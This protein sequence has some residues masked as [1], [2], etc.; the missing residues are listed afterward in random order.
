MGAIAAA[1]RYE[2]IRPIASGGMATVYL[3]RASGLGG[4]ERLVAIKRMHPHIAAEPDFVSMFLDEARLAAGIRHPNVV[5]TIDVDQGPEGLFLVMEYVDGTSLSQILRTMHTGRRRLPIGVTLRIMLDVL[6]GL[7]AAHEL[8]TVD[9]QPLNLVHRDVSPPNILV[10]LDGVARITDF[11]VARAEARITSTR[12]GTLKGKIAYMSP[13]QLSGHTID[14]RADVYAAGVLLWEMLVGRRLF[15]GDDPGMLMSRVLAGPTHSPA[16]LESDIPAAIDA[17]C[18]TAL[19]PVDERYPTAAAFAE[20]L[21]DAAD[22]SGIRVANARRVGE[23]VKDV[24]PVPPSSQ[25]AGALP[26]L[27]SRTPVVEGTP[28]HSRPILSAP[29]LA[30][31]V[32]PPADQLTTAP[33]PI[34]VFVGE[35]GPASGAARRRVAMVGG[36]ATL[37]LVIAGVALWMGREPRGHSPAGSTVNISSPPPS[38][39]GSP[40]PD[41]PAASASDVPGVGTASPSS[42]AATAT[43]TARPRTRPV[44]APVTPPPPPPHPTATATSTGKFHPINP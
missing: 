18:M 44:V 6:A 33:A 21:D 7:Q 24:G 19:R 12:E 13:E 9:G 10:G 23:I 36:V 29:G 38:T 4:F 1:G 26:A 28:S 37:V 31:S 5:A 27:S 3:A 34:P 41:V 8:T 39:A 40:P 16:Q 25:P 15:T 14:R 2:T 30:R 11:G 20:A 17:V 32:A 22:D 35:E 42:T 43:A